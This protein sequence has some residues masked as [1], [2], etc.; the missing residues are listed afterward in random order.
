MRAGVQVWA[1]GNDQGV[2]PSVEGA[3][4]W[5]FPGL[6]KGWLTVGAVDLDGRTLWRD[7]NIC[8]IAAAW[9]RRRP[10]GKRRRRP[11]GPVI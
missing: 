7:G 1:A 11:R 3:A 4:P 10:R 8:G 2:T 9:C 6:E 5:Y